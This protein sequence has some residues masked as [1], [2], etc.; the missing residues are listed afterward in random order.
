MFLEIYVYERSYLFWYEEDIPE[1]HPSKLDI[2]CIFYIG[3]VRRANR[4]TVWHFYICEV[5]VVK[6]SYLKT[7]KGYKFFVY[8]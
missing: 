7:S 5:K 2:S 6:I 3:R 4:A 8:Q 1:V